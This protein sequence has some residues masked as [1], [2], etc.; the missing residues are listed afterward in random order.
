MYFECGFITMR[1]HVI[2]RFGILIRF[3]GWSKLLRT[4]ISLRSLAVSYSRVNISIRILW[5]VNVRDE[6]MR[7]AVER[8]FK[9]EDRSHR[10]VAVSGSVSHFEN[11]RISMDSRSCFASFLLTIAFSRGKSSIYRKPFNS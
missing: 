1:L 8:F 11:R 2:Y 10:I 3:V 7:M 6:F 5:Y 4:L 9:L